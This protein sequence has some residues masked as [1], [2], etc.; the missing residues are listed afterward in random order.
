VARLPVIVGLGGVNPAGRLSLHHAY[1]RLVIDA[2]NPRAQDETYRSLAQLMNLDDADSDAA[3]Q[4]MREHTLIRRIGLFDTDAIYWQRNATLASAGAPLTF[5]LSKRQLPDQIPPGWTIID[6][7]ARDVVVAV[8]SSID[9]LL[10]DYRSS[11]VTSAGQ[12]PTG[13]DPAALYQSRSHPRALQIAVYGASDAVRSLGFDWSV[14]RQRVAPDQFSVYAGSAMGQLDANGFGGLLQAGLN[15]K[16]ATSKQTA[17]GMSEMAGDFVNA[18][19]LGTVGSTGTAIGACATWLYNLRLAIDDISSGRARVAIVGNSE[20][21]ITPEVIEGFRTMGALAE[22]EALMALDGRTDGPDNRRACRPF[23]DNCG[24]T[25][26]ESSVFAILMDDALALEL[27]ANI[28]GAAAGVYVS[29]DGYKKSIPGP[30]IGNYL[31]MAKAMALARSIVGDDGL[32]QRS[33]VQAHGTGTPQNRVTES[34]ILNELARTFRIDEWIVGAVKAY[35][36]HS[37]GPASGDQVCA[38]LGAWQYGFVPGIAT[39]DHVASDV[40]ASNLR[41]ES[42]HVEID[43]EAMDVTFVNSKGF[44]GNN[45]TGVFLSPTVTRRMLERR[46][47]KAAMRD[48]QKLNEAVA[49]A[50]G[51]YDERMMRGELKPIYQFGEGVLEGN[52]LDIDAAAIRL[53]G[54]EQPLGLDVPNP[55]RDMTD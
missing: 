45:A 23:S 33:Y 50:I 1:R 13:F 20:A 19:V 25:L 44:G 17:L 15:G 24:F 51:A 7:G 28:L 46:H 27:G 49:A 2:L 6:D 26:G 54:Y 18:Y 48:Y 30:G 53:P 40:H 9:V 10:P 31:T 42:S 52:D 35:V 36:G 4:Y 8:E 39:I 41:I 55:F 21:P 16:R 5:R 32:R 12:L 37:L 47:G 22:D 38:V 43:R 29:A 14:L 11:R 3:R 34:H